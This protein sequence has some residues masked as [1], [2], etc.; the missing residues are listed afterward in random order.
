MMVILDVDATELIEKLAEELKKIDDI[1]PPEWAKFVKTGHFKERPPVRDDWWY[2]R[3]AAILRKIYKLGPIGVARLRRIYGGKKN[4]GMKTEHHY[5]ASGNIIRKIL[6]QL[7]KAGLIEQ[8]NGLKRGKIVTKKGK[9]LLIK[10][11]EQ[12][13]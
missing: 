9:E 13:K 2:V 6:Q 4:R 1:K 10:V 11:A 5:P 3:A 8:V 7:S 12:V